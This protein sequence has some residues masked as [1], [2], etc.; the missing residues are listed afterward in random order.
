M[1]IKDL[2]NYFNHKW[3]KQDK[4]DDLQSSI[5]DLEYVK[6]IDDE[7]KEMLKEWKAIKFEDL[8][9]ETEEEFQKRIEETEKLKKIK[10]VAVKQT[11]PI[12]INADTAVIET[13][14]KKANSI[15][16]GY[17]TLINVLL[18]QYAD[19]KINIML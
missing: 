8:K 6:P 5:E 7:E 15:G 4:W 2:E 14:K 1:S 16:M 18:K 9:D 3:T 12:T 11:K 19:G 17:Q 13:I 10:F